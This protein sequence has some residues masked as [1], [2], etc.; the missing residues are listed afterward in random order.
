MAKIKLQTPIILYERLVY[1]V[2]RT[3][4]LYSKFTVWYVFSNVPKVL[5]RMNRPFKCDVLY[6]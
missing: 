2:N 3:Y 5:D 1:N 4:S 6:Q